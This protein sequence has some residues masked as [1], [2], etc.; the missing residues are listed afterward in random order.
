M[1]LGVGDGERAGNLGSGMDNDGVVADFVPARGGETSQDKR[2]EAIAQGEGGGVDGRGDGS[3]F[4]V[5]GTLAVA[6][7][8][9]MAR[10]GEVGGHVATE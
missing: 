7:V 5:E 6:K 4:S 10:T 9:A 1:V 2:G 3:S 8:S